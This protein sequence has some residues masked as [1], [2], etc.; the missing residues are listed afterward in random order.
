MSFT[1]ALAKSAFKSAQV[2][3]V[4]PSRTFPDTADEC[5]DGTRLSQ[6]ALL[7]IF[8]YSRKSPISFS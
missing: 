6:S 2:D 5:A 4:S 1:G 3:G 8:A 7:I